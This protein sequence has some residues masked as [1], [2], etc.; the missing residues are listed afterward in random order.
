MEIFRFTFFKKKKTLI[1]FMSFS[2]QLPFKLVFNKPYSIIFTKKTSFLGYLLY[3]LKNFI[4][5]RNL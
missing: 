3:K 4:V 1:W 5:L 2:N